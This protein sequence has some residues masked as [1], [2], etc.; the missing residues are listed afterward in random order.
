MVMLTASM[1]SAHAQ[2]AYVWL[3]EDSKT[4]TF[5]YD[6]DRTTRAGTTFDLN[7][8]KEWPGWHQDY[9][10]ATITKV[11]I[12]PSFANV[13]PTSTFYWFGMLYKLEEISGLNYLNTSEVTN[14]A[15]M[16]TSFP[17][18]SLDL[19]NFDTSKVTDM[20]GMF[21]YCINLNSL[22][23]S[24]FD[25]SNLTSSSI[26]FYYCSN[27]N[28]LKIS[29]TMENL[30]NDACRGAGGTIIAPEGFDFGVDITGAYFDWKGGRFRLENPIPI[31]PP[32]VDPKAYVVIS[33]NATKMTFYYD[34]YREERSG[35]VFG[36]EPDQYG[37]PLWRG[38]D[39]VNIFNSKTNWVEEV[40]FDPSF[41]N[42]RPKTTKHWFGAMW[43]L[44]SI[45]GLEYLNTSEVT[46]MSFMFGRCDKM[47]EFDLSTFDVSNVTK[48]GQLFYYDRALQTLTLP[49]GME[50]ISSDACEG[51]GST[52]NPCVI[53]VPED[54]D[55]GVD[56]T[57]DYFKWKS[58]YFKGQ[59]LP[60]VIVP[61][62]YAWLSEDSK[63]LT[64]SYD[65]ERASREETTYDL[66]NPNTGL[67]GWYYQLNDDVTKVVFEPAFA[68]ARPTS[69]SMWFFDM[70]NIKEVIGINYLN[71]SEV[72]DM[73][74][75][76]YGCSSLQELDLSSFDTSNLT[77]LNGTFYNCSSLKSLDV[78]SFDTSKV[79]NFGVTFRGCSSLEALD[80]SNF[81]ITN[82][83]RTDAMFYYCNNLRSLS[84]SSSMTSLDDVD[85]PA[86]NGIGT[87]W[88]P[89]LIIAP[90]GFDFGVDTS[91]DYFKWKGGYFTL[92]LSPT[93]AYAWM[94]TDGTTLT[95][96]YDDK[97]DERDGTTYYLNGNGETPEWFGGWNGDSS[98]QKVIFNPSF[99]DV[100]PIDTY[101]WFGMMPRLKEVIG[102][103]FL[104]TSDCT[105]LGFMFYGSYNIETLDVSNF[106]ISKIEPNYT[107]YM[108]GNC[109]GLEALTISSSMNNLH[110]EA[111]ISVGS[112]DN[113]CLIIAPEGFDF[114]VDTSGDYF[115]WKSG[116]FTLNPS[117]NKTYAWMSE[118]GKTLTFCYDDKKRERVG[119]TY[120]LNGEWE[121]P[122][123]FPGWG[124]TSSVQ[125]V[126]FNPSFADVK[127]TSTYLWFAYMGELEEIKG[128]NFLNTS[129]CT[130][131]YCMFYCCLKLKTLDVSNLDIS[132]S[133]STWGMLGY[134]KGLEKLTISSSMGSLDESAC[135]YVGTAE[136]PCLLIAPEGFDFGVD[137]S[138][139]Y[140]QWKTGYFMLENATPLVT[141][142][143]GDN[144]VPL[145]EYD[146]MT[147]DV[148]LDDY[149]CQPDKW[150]SL[151]VPFDLS[152][153]QL[154]EAFGENVNIQEMIGCTWDAENLTMSIN[155]NKVTEIL[156]G[157]PYLLRVSDAVNDPKFEGVTINSAD[158]L[159]LNFGDCEM[160]GVLNA[161]PLPMG[162]K[163][164]LF[165]IN[166]QF[167]YPA[168]TNPLPAMRCYFHL[169]GDAAGANSVALNMEDDPNAIISVI[170]DKAADS[171]LYH[172]L[173]GIATNRPHRGVYI[174]NGKKV[175][176]K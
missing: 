87:P 14:M 46:D 28:P 53:N 89:C 153:D 58:G 29:S 56:T 33:D 5:C 71:T 114:G 69:T 130:N 129:N 117:L 115:V 79:T 169:L 66:F 55:F 32:E 112:A 13:K 64:F 139:D 85:Y 99:A 127:P 150:Y 83:T 161:T 1:L 134:C 68:D 80:V 44:T 31:I 73:M 3:S 12:E 126:V 27:L 45:Q 88:K 38:F 147:V 72:T 173:Q 155:F 174:I 70:S 122:A 21:Y 2:E 95:F 7:E 103:N 120:Y 47:T 119:T 167:Y 82:A 143:G 90:E 104:N 152:N 37:Y 157:K 137:T 175:V 59:G 135:Q 118:D 43:E 16:F 160:I 166:N 61:E 51:V 50:N 163:S 39:G 6:A 67:P 26:M 171:G 168:T 123:W 131:M 158:P 42:A 54:F 116:Y 57:G 136:N 84:I 142:T 154:K 9:D 128:L 125:K 62:A 48:S 105:N 49:S 96:C 17:L 86:C 144:E 165:I 36:I 172:S 4:L 93:K 63:T 24:N 141:L 164:Y 30:D 102:L 75:M 148:E 145:S 65:F 20:S 159:A 60:P 34:D 8:G 76:F 162:D 138:G 156:A 11:V 108:F 52:E 23:V 101:L 10:E 107:I 149:T 92:T 91:G 110:D 18:T 19:S 98:V 124:I 78:S 113:P 132:N 170:T 106:D 94:S 25:T 77:N 81:D 109:R 121:N 146:G 100:R 151:C 176:V 133:T 97:K 22:D 140:F 40:V 74:C 15:G 35:T 41:A 111:C